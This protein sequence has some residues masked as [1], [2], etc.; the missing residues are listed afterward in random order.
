MVSFRSS[1]SSPWGVTG[2]HG[3]T[4]QKDAIS[5]MSEKEKSD[6]PSPSMIA[7]LSAAMSKSPSS[8]T[9]VTFGKLGILKCSPGRKALRRWFERDGWTV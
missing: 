3:S 1:A 8:L 7:N 6:E 9:T 2:L 5:E 4:K